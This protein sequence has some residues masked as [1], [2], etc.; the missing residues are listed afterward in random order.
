MSSFHGLYHHI[1]DLNRQPALFTTNGPLSIVSLHRLAVSM[2]L[3][4]FLLFLF[5]VKGY[6]ERWWHGILWSNS[7]LSDWWHLCAE[8][9]WKRFGQQIEM[10]SLDYAA[11]SISWLMN[12]AQLYA[13]IVSQHHTTGVTLNHLRSVIA[14]TCIMLPVQFCKVFGNDTMC[15]VN[16]LTL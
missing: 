8:L 11:P 12:F 10:L 7:V 2:N 15:L 1:N 9:S 4:V 14:A 13:S 6:T 16:S 3:N 5:Q